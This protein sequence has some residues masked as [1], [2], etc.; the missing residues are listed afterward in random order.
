MIDGFARCIRAIV[1]T[2]A[3]CGD[4]VV[5]KIRRNPAKR[6]MTSIAIVATGYM[7]WRFANRYYIVVTG[8]AGA[9]DLRVIHQL[10]WLPHCRD[11]AIFANVGGLNVGQALAGR[12]RTVVASTAAA[13]NIG[14]VKICR[15]PAVSGMAVVAVITARKVRRGFATGNDVVMAG[16]AGTND[17]RMVHC[18]GRLPERRAMTI[19]TGIRRL[20]MRHALAARLVA[21]MAVETIRRVAGVIKYRRHPGRGLVAVIAHFVRNNV[22]GRLAACIHTVVAG[23]TRLHYGGVVHVRYGTPRGRCMAIGTE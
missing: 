16:N 13:N 11:V 10:Y 18:N 17:L 22:V 23:S 12:I 2:A 20:N 15:Y 9:N 8:I 19:L 6:G 7:R 5:V 3:I 1:A 4:V 21:V 14:M